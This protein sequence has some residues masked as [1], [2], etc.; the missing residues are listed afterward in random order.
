MFFQFANIVLIEKRKKYVVVWWNHS[1]VFPKK[2]TLASQ[3]REQ[4]LIEE[5]VQFNVCQK[6]DE[7]FVI[8]KRKRQSTIARNTVPK[9]KGNTSHCGACRK[10]D[11]P[12]KGRKGKKVDWVDC[13]Y[14]NKG[15][16]LD[17]TEN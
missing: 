6:D 13:D 15:T 3:L 2:E 14:C 4:L 11:P 8:N 7:V 17:C 9:K 16:H 1:S 10:E 5:V 12:R